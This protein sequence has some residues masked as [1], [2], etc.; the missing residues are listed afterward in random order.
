MDVADTSLDWKYFSKEVEVYK[1]VTQHKTFWVSKAQV[2]ALK[3]LI[4]DIKHKD[5]MVFIGDEGVRVFSILGIVKEKQ[6]FCQLPEE[7]QRSL[8]KT[9]GIFEEAELEGFS[10][11]VR[12]ILSDVK[13]L[14]DGK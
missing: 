7:L 9:E 6:R 14:G 4:G 3:P 11:N 12:L 8:L 2:E 5:R 1:I 13:G 10:K